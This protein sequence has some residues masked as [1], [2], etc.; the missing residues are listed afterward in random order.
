VN[1]KTIAI[2]RLNVRV[3]GPVERSGREFGAAFGRQL[4]AQIASSGML[5]DWPRSGRVDS[6][7]A[8]RVNSAQQAAESIAIRLGRK[9]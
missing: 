5:R 2:D 8:G 4:L 7:D 3:K 1:G 9:S 6:L